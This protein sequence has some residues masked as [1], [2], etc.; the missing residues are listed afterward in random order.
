MAGK[1]ISPCLKQKMST[2]L[3]DN[4][5]NE[6]IKK[7]SDYQRRGCLKALDS[8]LD[9]N[10][11][12]FFAQP[13]NPKID[14]CPDYF[15]YI[16][17][18]MD[19]GTIREKLINNEYES[20]AHFKSDV[21]LVWENTYRY[22]GKDAMISK[23]ARQLQQEFDGMT[24]FVTGDDVADWVSESEW[25]KSTLEIRIYGERLVRFLKHPEEWPSIQNEI[26]E[27][28]SYAKLLSR[29][30]K[31][32]LV[33]DLNRLTDDGIIT[34]LITF[35]NQEEPGLTVNN[36]LDIELDELSDITIANLKVKLNSLINSK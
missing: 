17:K 26:K 28:K 9:Y 25:I 16:I 30:E 10:I 29:T 6:Q 18:P 7:M 20:T 1:F 32:K 21:K 13:V 3:G 2:D 14:H 4:A 5:S 15:D 34:E 35:I 11:S 36:T 19:L 12:T 27:Q 33:K 23:L 31:Q 8:I 22:H 24:F